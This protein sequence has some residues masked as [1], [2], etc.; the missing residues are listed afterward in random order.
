MKHTRAGS[1]ASPWCSML[2]RKTL[3]SLAWML[4][5]WRLCGARSCQV[6]WRTC[7]VEMQH[8]AGVACMLHGN[9]RVPLW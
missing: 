1:A 7:S 6:S 5:W 3:A 4:R 9:S 2:L 8:L